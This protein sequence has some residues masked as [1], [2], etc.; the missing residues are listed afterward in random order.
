MLPSLYDRLR[1]LGCMDGKS[2]RLFLATIFERDGSE[3]TATVSTM[4][5]RGFVKFAQFN[6]EEQIFHGRLEGIDDRIAV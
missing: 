3:G 1:I 5:Y 2:M 6:A 4:K